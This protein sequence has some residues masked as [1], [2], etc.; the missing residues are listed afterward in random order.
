MVILEPIEA[1]EL[2]RGSI[3]LSKHYDRAIPR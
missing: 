2:G 3:P 1:T